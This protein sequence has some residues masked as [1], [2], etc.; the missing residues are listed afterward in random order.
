MPAFTYSCIIFTDTI[1]VIIITVIIIFLSLS[2]IANAMIIKKGA[3]PSRPLPCW[4]GGADWGEDK[5]FHN[6]WTFWGI[7]GCLPYSADKRSKHPPCIKD[8]AYCLVITKFRFL[9]IIKKFITK[10]RCRILNFQKP[11]SLTLVWRCLKKLNHNT[12]TN[13]NKLTTKKNRYKCS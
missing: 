11:W 7:G 9:L 13:T 8:D 3:K 10:F 12:N 4:L 1:I 5:G 2:R 6:F